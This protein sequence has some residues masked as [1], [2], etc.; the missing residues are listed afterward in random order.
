MIEMEE[1]RKETWYG[2]LLEKE[3]CDEESATASLA[4]QH[5]WESNQYL[6][7]RS[8]HN[9]TLLTSLCP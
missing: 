1:Q 6:R 9:P 7:G 3:R 2:G 8:S 5:G 4:K